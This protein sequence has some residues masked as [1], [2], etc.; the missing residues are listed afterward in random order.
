MSY[1]EMKE[2]ELLGKKY[3]QIKR[4]YKKQVKVIDLILD[5][6]VYFCQH[7][8]IVRDTM[9]ATDKETIRQR[10]YNLIEEMLED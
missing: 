5:D 4:Q 2:Y 3:R 7:I 1:V 9:K 10:Y 6:L 8:E